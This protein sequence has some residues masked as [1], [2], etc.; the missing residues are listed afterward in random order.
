MKLSVVIPVYN[1]EKT[2]RALL[3]KVLRVKIDKELVIVDDHSS[4]GSGAI[5][6]EYTR[7]PNV[8][9]IYHERNYGKGK[10]IRSG[11]EHITGDIVIIQDA[12]LEYEPMDYLPLLDSLRKTGLNVVYGSRFLGNRRASSLWHRSVN[13]F[14]TFLTNVLFGSRLTD[15]ET[16]YKL[17][18]ADFLKS[19]NLRSNGFE[20]EVELTAKTLKQG[21]K[22]AE[23]P[24][25]YK[26]RSFHDGKKIGWKDGL[27]A[28][29]TLLRY[30][31]LD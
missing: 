10:A 9:A 11:I 24:I 29:W 21:E 26:G 18:R 1:E 31:F 15:M 25:S 23:T 5:I 22:I 17:F 28:I 2:L 4:D 13:Q 8:K 20:V 19:L 3:E 7:L 16:C 12:D 14:L 6:R 30:R 27:Q